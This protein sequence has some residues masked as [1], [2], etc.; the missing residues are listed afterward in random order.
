MTVVPWSNAETIGA[1]TMGAPGLEH[2]RR[3][4]VTQ[5]ASRLH[6]FQIKLIAIIAVG[7]KWSVCHGVIGY[8]AVSPLLHVLFLY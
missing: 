8:V 5:S 2:L 3:T 7:A 4:S 1:D 6:S